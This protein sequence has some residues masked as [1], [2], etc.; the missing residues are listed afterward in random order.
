MSLKTGEKDVV[1]SEDSSNQKYLLQV[2]FKSD[3]K[4]LTIKHE[5]I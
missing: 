1:N 3:Y 2:A 5:I 4:L